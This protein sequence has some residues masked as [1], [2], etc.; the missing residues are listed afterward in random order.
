MELTTAISADPICR[1]HLTGRE[2]PERP[3]RFDAVVNG[4]RQAGL[5]EHFLSLDPRAATEDEL[6]LCHTREYLRIVRHVVKGES[7]PLDIGRRTKVWTT[8]QR[9]AI[10]VRDHGRCRWPNC[11]RRTCDIHHV[12]WYDEGGVTAVLKK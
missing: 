8:A 5:L 2:H 1:E 6:A 3:E 9:R 7:E 11:W 4:L 10:I 12:V